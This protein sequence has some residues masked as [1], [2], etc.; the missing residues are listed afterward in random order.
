MVVL[1]PD[2]DTAA[3]FILTTTC[4]IH[5]LSRLNTWTKQAKHTWTKQ[6]NH[7]WT[8]MTKHTWTKQT[9]QTRCT[10]RDTYTHVDLTENY[11]IDLAELCA[12]QESGT[13]STDNA[14]NQ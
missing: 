13:D 8:M 3:E 5:G 9:K 10:H 4:N 6:A 14:S 11:E 7:T 2:P 1:R 12:A